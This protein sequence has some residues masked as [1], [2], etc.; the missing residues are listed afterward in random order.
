MEPSGAVIASVTGG[1]LASEGKTVPGQVRLFGAATSD[2]AKEAY[3]IRNNGNL[4]VR[5]TWYESNSGNCWLHLDESNSGTFTFDSGKIAVMPKGGLP[6][7]SITI[8]GFKGK[9]SFISTE[10]VDEDRVSVSGKSPDANVLLL[11]V[12]G[13]EKK[14]TLELNDTTAKACMIQSRAF[15]DKPAGTKPV[16]DIGKPDPQ[17]IRDM[18]RPTREAVPQPL[19]P[20]REGVTDVRIERVVVREVQVGTHLQR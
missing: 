5:D 16:A 14:P 3:V 4:L 6:V 11:G 7:A 20:Y 9:V 18:L 13:H 8:N 12:E 1:P 10:F 17:W 19:L 2:A 15:T